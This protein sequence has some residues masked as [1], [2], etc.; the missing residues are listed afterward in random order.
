MGTLRTL[1]DMPYNMRIKEISGREYLYEVTDRRGTMK[2]KGALDPA[3]QDEFDN[4]N[5]DKAELKGRL[6]RARETLKEQT[7]A[8]AARC[9]R[10]TMR[11]VTTPVW[12]KAPSRTLLMRLVMSMA[13]APDYA[14]KR[15]TLA[16]IIG[17]S[18]NPGG[19][20]KAQ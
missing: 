15:R 14:D 9:M 19:R 8:L 12:S 17:L 2:S 11:Q 16:L 1:N 4:H 3:K 10:M 5:A 13:T 20:G 6:V 18:R 7:M